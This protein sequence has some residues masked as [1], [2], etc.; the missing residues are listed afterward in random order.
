MSHIEIW[1]GGP[2]VGVSGTMGQGGEGTDAIVCFLEV[3]IKSQF[4]LA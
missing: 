2:M 4:K 1:N 3:K